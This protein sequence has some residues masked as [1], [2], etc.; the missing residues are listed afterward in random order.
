LKKKRLQFDAAFPGASYG[1]VKAKTEQG[2]LV[3]ALGQ[4]DTL[5][6][7]ATLGEPGAIQVNDMV[8]V[9]PVEPKGKGPL[10]AGMEEAGRILAG[11]NA[12][13]RTKRP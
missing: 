13:M 8:L 5:H 4:K 2:F 11:L 9:I 6:I 10:I 7:S 3:Q 12:Y 1:T